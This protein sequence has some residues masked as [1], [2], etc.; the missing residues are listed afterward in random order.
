MSKHPENTKEA[1]DM[2]LFI[3]SWQSNWRKLGNN[4]KQLTKY[5][6]D[7]AQII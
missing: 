3:N 5:V 2:F 6:V 7:I 1:N 4:F